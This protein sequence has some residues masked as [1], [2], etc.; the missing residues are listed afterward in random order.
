VRIHYDHQVFSLQNAG[1]A[2]RYQ[3]ELLHYLSTVPDVQASL[4]LGLHHSAYPLSELPLVYGW[5]TS[6]APGSLRY[7]LNEGLESLSSLSA[8]RYDIYHPTYFRRMPAVRARR[9]V[10]TYHDSTYEEFP[11]LFPDAS[12]V[13]RYKTRLYSQV[14]KVIC[15][16][17]A[18]RRGLLRFY[19]VRPEQ[20]CVVYH[21]LRPLPRSAAAAGELKSHMRRDFLLYVGAR[22]A[23]KNFPLFIE[24]FHASRLPEAFDLLCL[25]GAR[26]TPSETDLITKL[27]LHDRFVCLPSA[28]DELLGEAYATAALFVYPSLS[29]GFGMPPLEAMAA[30]CAVAASNVTAIPEVCADAPF[31]FDP[32]DR[33]SIAN[34]LCAAVNDNEARSR[35]IRRGREVAALYSWEKCGAETLAAYR[36]CF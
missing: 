28:S 30:G 21:G 34:T 5:R 3:Y 31:Y 4:F 8:G 27:Q 35:A 13:I 20:T 25:G 18:S 15:I 36:S 12:S 11:H 24:A 19:P 22:N 32:C 9:L 17:E 33:A 7:A 1:G 16:S 29:E 26:L 2:S 23:H 10:T 6:L 14:D